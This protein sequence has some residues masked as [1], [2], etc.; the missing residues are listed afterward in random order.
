[1]D[2]SDFLDRN[3]DR[4]PLF[5]HCVTDVILLIKYEGSLELSEC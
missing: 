2:N 3:D 1:M 4:C 5:T